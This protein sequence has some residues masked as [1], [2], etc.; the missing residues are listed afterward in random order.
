MTG[1]LSHGRQQGADQSGGALEGGILLTIHRLSQGGADRVAMLLANGYAAAGIPTGIAVLRAGGEA[2]DLLQA[3]LRPDVALYCA[4]PP[5]GS[6][7]LEL[8]RGL[9]HIERIVAATRPAV[10][11]ASSSNMGLVT[12]LCGRLRAARAPRYAMKLT[13]P[14]VRPSDRGRLRAHYRRWLYRF[15]FSC[16]DRVLLLS[17]AESEE[18]E[19]LFPDLSARFEVVANPYVTDEMFAGRSPPAR[20]NP[21]IVLTLARMMP[22][23]RLD[24]LLEAFAAMTDRDARLVIVGDGPLRAALTR[25]AEALGIADRVDMP[26]FAEDVVSWLRQSSLFA[27]S[28]DYEGLPAAVLEALA[29]G[30]PVVTTDC[31]DAARSILS[32]LEGCAVVPRDDIGALAK[33]MDASLSGTSDPGA[34]SAVARPFTFEP[35]VAEHVELIRDLISAG[36]AARFN[37]R[38]DSLRQ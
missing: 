36:N 18:M 30:V 2:Q 4:G 1:T 24:R 21:R 17:A 19:R 6:R 37:T 28:S 12:G 32:G 34:L 10:V 26:G 22:Q 13:N 7:H 27:L 29:C 16:Y 38:G 8:V 35:A 23:K 31:F 9:R 15:I 14:V 25:Q 20:S 33:A 3:M 11:L 5:I